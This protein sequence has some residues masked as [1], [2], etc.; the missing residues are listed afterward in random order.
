MSRQVV[1][2]VEDIAQPIVE[3]EGLE[4]VDI[5]YSKEG[6]N[7]YLR[8]FIDQNSGAINLDHCSRV[9]ELLSNELD[10]LDPIPTAYFLEVSSP[11]AE[12]PLKKEEDFQKAIGKHV[13]VST[14]ATIEGQKEFEGSLVSFENEH[15]TIKIGDKNFTIPRQQIAN[16]RLAILF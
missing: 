2:V 15:V 11:G 3:A 7:W 14:Y 10:R 6:P 4:L 9:S 13:H 5:E 12:R 16:A 8:I 1:K